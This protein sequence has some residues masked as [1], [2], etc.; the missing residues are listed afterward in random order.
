M[1]Y[2]SVLTYPFTYVEE[3]SAYRIGSFAAGINEQYTYRKEEL[4]QHIL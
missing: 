4:F 3:D 1:C 2:H